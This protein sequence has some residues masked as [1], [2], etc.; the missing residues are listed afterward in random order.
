MEKDES[1]KGPGLALGVARPWPRLRA[2]PPWRH[3]WRRRQAVVV[4]VD[5][6]GG[7]KRRCGRLGAPYASEGLPRCAAED[8]H[9]Y[10]SFVVSSP[11]DVTLTIDLM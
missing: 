1:G 10:T 3:R 9:R 8:K 7:E 5:H 4:R 11:P 2:A 6:G